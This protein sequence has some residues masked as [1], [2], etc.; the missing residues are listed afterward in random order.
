VCVREREMLKTTMMTSCEDRALWRAPGRL[1]SK[2]SPYDAG[3]K[4]GE[5]KEEGTSTSIMMN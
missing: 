1:T 2:Y 4:K 3:I 5:T